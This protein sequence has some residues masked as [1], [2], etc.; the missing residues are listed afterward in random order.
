MFTSRAEYRLA[1]RA[2]MPTSVSPTEALPF[3]CVGSERRKKFHMKLA[4][5]DEARAFAKSVSLSPSER[6]SMVSC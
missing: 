1:L 4:A 6:R 3:G 2:T 5:L